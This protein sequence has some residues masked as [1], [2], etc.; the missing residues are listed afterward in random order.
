MDHA[1][2]DMNTCEYKAKH[3]YMCGMTIDSGRGLDFFRHL[4]HNSN[5]VFPTLTMDNHDRGIV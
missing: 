3:K 2:V 4:S 5:P 1:T